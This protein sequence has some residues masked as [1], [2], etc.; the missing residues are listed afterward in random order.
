MRCPPSGGKADASDCAA[1]AGATDQT[2]ILGGPDLGNRLR[3]RVTAANAAGSATATSNASAIVGS[4]SLAPQNT[5]EPAISGT[6]RVGSLLTAT[7]GS[8]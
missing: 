8:W 4:A 6:A 3:V 1:I 5:G 7:Q 2:Y